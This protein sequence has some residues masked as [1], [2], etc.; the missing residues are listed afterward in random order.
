MMG[1]IYEPELG[2]GV[3]WNDTAFGINWPFEPVVMSERDASYPD[4]SRDGGNQ[5]RFAPPFRLFSQI[6][7][8]IHERQLFMRANFP[9][10]LEFY[11]GIELTRVMI[12][13]KNVSLSAPWP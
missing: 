5:L 10:D 12:S 4:F 3:R 13:S 1:E 6:G 11:T 7:D 8:L 9:V 2:R